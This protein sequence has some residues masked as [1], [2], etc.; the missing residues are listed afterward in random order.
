M[1]FLFL[2]GRITAGAVSEP[3]VC[4]IREQSCINYGRHVEMVC[5]KANLLAQ[6]FKDVCWIPQSRPV[7]WA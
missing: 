7:Q 4:M 6:K 3:E 2:S 1:W 5:E